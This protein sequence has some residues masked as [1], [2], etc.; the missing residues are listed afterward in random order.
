MDNKR[1]MD[2]TIFTNLDKFIEEI[3][4]LKQLKALRVDSPC[5]AAAH[6]YN[7]NLRPPGLPEPGHQGELTQEALLQHMLWQREGQDHLPVLQGRG[8]KC[9]TKM[10]LNAMKRNHGLRHEVQDEDN[11]GTPTEVQEE[12]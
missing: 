4:G 10:V 1:L 2:F 5:L 3:E 9:P 8:Q 12:D 11:Q 6:G 7:K